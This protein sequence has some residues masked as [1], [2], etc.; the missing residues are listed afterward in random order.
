[1]APDDQLQQIGYFDG[2]SVQYSYDPN[3][4]RTSMQDGLGTTTWGYDPLN[5]R[6]VQDDPFSRV[7]QTAYDAAS[8]RVG[9]VYAD[10]NEVAYAYSPNNWLATVTDPHGQV[11][12]YERDK[13]GN[14]THTA[15][16]NAMVTDKTYD[17]VYRVLTL[18]NRQ[19]EGA[20]KT[21][22]AF[23][24][25][26]NLVGHVTQVVKKYG[27]QQPSEITET[28]TYDGLHRLATTTISPLKNNGDDVVMAYGYDAVGNR[29]A[30]MS[31]DDLTTQ[32]PFDG[33]RKDYEYNAGN[34][35]GRVGKRLFVC[36][37][38]ISSSL[39]FLDDVLF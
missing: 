16:P 38:F 10:G 33:F 25:A 17:R 28:Y 26:Y 21:H 31:N 32:E 9:L 35:P 4:N 23:D 20:K 5:R 34:Q 36:P 29:L 7:L 13:V 11:T 8:N 27:W 2:T 37:P 18:A 15:N 6:I 1:L 14:I 19:V 30:W 22:S 3:N 12:A 39:V 24:Y